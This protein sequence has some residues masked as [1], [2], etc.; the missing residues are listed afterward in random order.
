[1]LSVGLL[2]SAYSP[3]ALRKDILVTHA[4]LYEMR[5]LLADDYGGKSGSKRTFS[6]K[7]LGKTPNKSFP[8]TVANEV[9]SSFI[10]TTLGFN[11]PVVLPH[12]V[13]S[14]PLALILWMEPASRDQT[15]PP[16]TTKEYAAF[17]DDHSDII[18]GSI[19]LDLYLG[20][21][22]REIGPSRR[23]ISFDAHQ[24][25]ILFDFG[26]ALFYRNRDHREIRAGIE[27]LDAVEKDMAAMF[28]KTRENPGSLYFQFLND[29]SLVDKWCERIKQIPDYVIERAVE[30]IPQHITPPDQNERLR[31]IDFLKKRRDYLKSHIV[32]NPELFPGLNGAL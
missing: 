17:V 28:D 14:Q 16:M 11:V 29:R 9:V 2:V 5:E 32:S 26:N 1:M 31:L 27:R 19:V 8:Y 22:D 15:G 4:D 21:T 23:N 10:A 7:F 25:M 12:V 24:S 3:T 18:H 6:I 30:R 20:N 13:D